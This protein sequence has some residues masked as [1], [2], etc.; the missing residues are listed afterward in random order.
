VVVVLASARPEAVD[1]AVAAAVGARVALDLPSK[2]TRED[3]ITA[4][5]G[6]GLLGMV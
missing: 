1:C 5:V 2:E 6:A 4:Q 3:V